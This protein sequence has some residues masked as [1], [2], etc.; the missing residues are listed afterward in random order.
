MSPRLVLAAIALIYVAAP[1]I[2]TAKDSDPIWAAT[3]QASPEPARAPVMGLNN[4]TVRQVVRISLGGT[5][6]RVRFTNEFGDTPLKIGSAHVGLTTEGS[7]IKLGSD[8]ALT[9][10]G[11]SHDVVIPE[12]SYVYSDPVDLTVPSQGQIT[13]SLYVPG[14][15][16]NLTEHFFALQTAWI[17]AKDV[18]GATLI[19]GGTTITKRLLLSG[20]DVAVPRKRPVIV[21]LGDSTTGGF[22]STLDTDRRW[23]DRLTERFIAKKMQASVVNAGIGG[24]RLLHDFI[25]PN[26]LS[27]FDRDVLSQSG[28][29]HVVVLIGIN[30]FG[31]PGGRKIPQEE[32]T[33]EQ[34]VAGLRQMVSRAHSRG[35]KIYAGTLLPFGPIPERPGYYSELSAKKREALNQ[36]LRGS[37]EFDGVIDFDAALR[38]SQDAKS[39]Q[40]AYDSGDHL[41]PNDDGYKAMADAV[42]LKLF[43]FKLFD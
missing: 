12:H 28:V 22:G 34:M 35:V 25:G 8:R 18:T 9:F 24:N 33:L 27:R 3:W 6:F 23:T 29:S 43:D 17:A 26:A 31:L 11:G 13:I 10:G 19:Q 4:Q 7:S 39:L 14:N 37:K 2:A 1:P 15:E 38:D 41:N 21:A 36:W 32:V 5:R 30:D 40:A 42:D 16:K 20:V